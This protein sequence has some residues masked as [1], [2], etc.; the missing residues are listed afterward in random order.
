M[1]L[2]L[3]GVDEL[4]NSPDPSQENDFTCMLEYDPSLG[5][6]N[7]TMHWYSSVDGSVCS[8]NTTM[9]G[10]QHNPMSRSSLVKGC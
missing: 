6:G 10:Y 4:S 7:P 8:A 9:G 5:S 3:L 1:E 2:P